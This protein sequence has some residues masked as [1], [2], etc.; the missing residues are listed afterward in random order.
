MLAGYL[1]HHF[2][3][4]ARAVAQ[5][6]QMNLPNLSALADVVHQIVRVAFASQE[7]HKTPLLLSVGS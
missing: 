6:G 5:F 7:S 2:V 1:A 3:R 4:N